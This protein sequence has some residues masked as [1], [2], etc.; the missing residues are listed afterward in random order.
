MKI[1]IPYTYIYAERIT[2]AANVESA[3][4]ERNRCV[5]SYALSVQLFDV[6]SRFAPGG[7]GGRTNYE[8]MRVCPPSPPSL[9]LSGRRF[10]RKTILRRESIGDPSRFRGAAPLAPALFPTR[11][12]IPRA[13][14]KHSARPPLLP[15]SLPRG[16]NCER[17]NAPF[18]IPGRGRRLIVPRV[19][20]FTRSRHRL[21]GAD[22]AVRKGK[23]N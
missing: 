11:G 9:P 4:N 6:C 23:I 13:N 10:E 18:A 15:P 14:Y 19:F 16:I 22:S 7:G 17:I 12:S 3:P 5:Q 1:R 2:E 8:N 20:A 21:E